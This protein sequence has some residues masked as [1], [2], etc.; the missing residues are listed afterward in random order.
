MWSIGTLPQSSTP[1]PASRSNS[2]NQKART[3]TRGSGL[4]ALPFREKSGQQ[5]SLGQRDGTYVARNLGISVR[6]R[7][8]RASLPRGNRWRGHGHRGC[9]VARCFT[10]QLHSTAHAELGQQGRDVEFYC[11]FRKIQRRRDFFVGQAA[12]N[13]AKHFF[14]T[15]RQLYGAPYSVARLQQL[16]GLLRKPLERI[17]S[18]LH[19]NNVIPGRLAAN[20]AMHG[21]QAGGLLD[22]KLPVRAGFYMKMGNA[23]V[24]FIEKIEFAGKTRSRDIQMR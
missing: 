7:N 12:H 11:P 23:G 5:L 16:F 13:A 21:Q 19:H 4:C 10:D 14:F 3:A 15:A 22:R 24:L 2:E 1:Q 8:R 6:R 18:S 9:G 17:R 20:Q